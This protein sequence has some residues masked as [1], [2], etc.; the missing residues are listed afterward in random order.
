[1][2]EVPSHTEPARG[3]K[4]VPEG[5]LLES[6]SEGWVRHRCKHPFLATALLSCWPMAVLKALRR[7]QVPRVNGSL[8][9]PMY[10]G[11]TGLLRSLHDRTLYQGVG[12]MN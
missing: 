10:L 9:D 11:T 4:E 12:G 1:M 5:D 2:G 8:M 7:R 6:D 3:L